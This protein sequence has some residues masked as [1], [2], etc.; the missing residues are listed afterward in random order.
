M[1]QP[2][3]EFLVTPDLTRGLATKLKQKPEIFTYASDPLLASL[4]C[5]LGLQ[6]EIG[7]VGLDRLSNPLGV[8][9]E[10]ETTSD[11]D[12]SDNTATGSAAGADTVACASPSWHS[13]IISH[14]KEIGIRLWIPGVSEFSPRHE[15]FQHLLHPFSLSPDGKL[16]QIVLFPSQIA[17]RYEHKGLQLVIVRDW[18][19]FAFLN[20][21]ANVNYFKTNRW[22]IENNTARLQVELMARNQ[23]AF[24][25]THDLADHLLGG[26][27]EGFSLHQKFYQNIHTRYMRLLPLHK[28]FSLVLSYLIGVLLDDMVQPV[29]YGS[30]NHRLIVER[31]LELLEKSASLPQDL[32]E[33]FLPDSFHS[34]VKCLRERHTAELERHLTKFILDLTSRVTLTA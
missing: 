7:K 15:D 6:Y 9:F 5:C 31:T 26:N 25:G 16:H 22:E 8:S 19:L 30:E 18:A 10:T 21:D 3:Q 11:A 12:S 13:Q 1:Q 32:P 28:N 24:S 23:V 2:W 29:W 34:L 27:G 4:V 17:R 33:I 20:G 14:G